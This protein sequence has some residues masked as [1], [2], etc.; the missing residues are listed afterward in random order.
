MATLIEA[1]RIYKH[2]LPIDSNVA[3]WSVNGKIIVRKGE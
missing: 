3:F 1:V 2:V